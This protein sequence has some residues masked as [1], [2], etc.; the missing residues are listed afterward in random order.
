MVRETREPL[1]RV[2]EEVR[3]GNPGPLANY[4]NAVLKGEQRTE[5]EGTRPP[6]RESGAPEG[7][8]VQGRAK[9]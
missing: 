8:K 5:P 3:A 9:G 4:T 6:A 1:K 2:R 7:K